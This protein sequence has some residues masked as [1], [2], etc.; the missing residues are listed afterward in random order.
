MHK[1]NTIIPFKEFI[2]DIVGLTKTSLVNYPNHIA[3]TIFTKGC[4]MRCPFCHNASLVDHSSIHSH[5]NSEEII[6]FLVSRRNI[7]EGVC[8][9]GGEPS[10]QKEL[11]FFIEKIKN[12]GL[13]VK[14]D[15]N[16]SN[17]NLIQILLNQKLIDYIAMDIKN[18]PSKYNDT[19]HVSS[20]NIKELN[21]SVESIISSSINYEF[22]T[23]L[24]KEFH[25]H[26]DLLEIGKWLRGARQ[27]YI[28]KY[29]YTEH[30][31][32]PQQYT[33]FTKQ[34][35]TTFKNTLLSYI[36][37]VSLRGYE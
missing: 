33:A 17:S 31:I 37:N 1:Q 27:F 9:T 32:S 15:T 18:C 34:E 11:I 4:N 29:Q 28:Q 24:L 2:M 5:I 35:A 6:Q 23:T 22:R 30:Q 20:I 19:T 3:A 36:D 8:I 7:L 14:L 10:L 21:A 13:K 12:L 26:K 16:G 25:T